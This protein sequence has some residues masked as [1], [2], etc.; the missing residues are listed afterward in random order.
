MDI[1]SKP[2]NTVAASNTVKQALEVL[3]PRIR[4][5]YPSKRRRQPLSCGFMDNGPRTNGADILHR[6][7]TSLRLWTA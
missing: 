7:L 4:H 2:F 1:S 6:K 3:N 5:G